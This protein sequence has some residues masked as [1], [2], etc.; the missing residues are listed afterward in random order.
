MGLIGPDEVPETFLIE[1]PVRDGAIVRG[2]RVPVKVADIIAAAGPRVPS[3]KDAQREF[4]LGVY[5]LFQ[6]PNGP[7]AAKLAQARGMEA[8]LL[9]YFSTATGGRMTVTAH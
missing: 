9:Q 7:D 4:K 8:A 1:K 3:W 5:L 2:T 6:D